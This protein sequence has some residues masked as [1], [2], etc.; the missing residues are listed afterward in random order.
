MMTA[1]LAA[2]WLPVAS[3]AET[4]RNI[5][6]SVSV[7]AEGSEP[8]WD[9]VYTLELISQRENCPMPEGSREGI[10]RMAVKGGSTGA[11]RLNCETPGE[12]DYSLRQIPGKNRNCV[13]DERIFHLRI[14]VSEEAI[15]ID[16]RDS[17]GNSMTDI[18]FRNR[19][20]EPAWV[21]FSAWTTLDSVPPEDGAFSCLLLAEDGEQVATIKNQGHHVVFP[22]LRFAEAGT[23]RYMMK[24]IA[25][26]G[27]G[28]VYDRAVYTM[29]VTVH[30]DGDYVA[31]VS[32]TRN[33]EAYAGTP[34]F[35]NYTEGSIPRTGDKI[36]FWIMAMLLSGASLLGLCCL[37]QK[38]TGY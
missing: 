7:R 20:A 25:E 36:G 3:K 14:T 24:E 31:E 6:I 37:K 15:H 19:W 21:T 30:Q 33:G 10:Y 5:E 11:V 2:V 35:A 1:L 29:T 13:Y 32:C 17:E 4:N 38:I 12:Y 23:F 22:A 28:V 16:A 34:C 18:L 9:A 27:K 26:T 8:D